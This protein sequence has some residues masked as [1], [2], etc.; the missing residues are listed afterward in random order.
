[1]QHCYR[2]LKKIEAPQTYQCK[3]T[4]TKALSNKELKC[5]TFKMENG[6]LRNQAQQVKTYIL[7]N[8]STMQCHHMNVILRKE[9][10][11]FTQ[12]G[13]E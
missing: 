8:G 1:M 13:M 12:G 4:T 11:G 5:S 3:K 7:S 6:D 2:Q 10:K 9:Q